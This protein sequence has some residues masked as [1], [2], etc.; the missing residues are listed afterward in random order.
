MSRWWVTWVTF[1]PLLGGDRVTHC[2]E[3]RVI[4]PPC[5]ILDAAFVASAILG[6]P[7][8]AATLLGKAS[9]V[10]PIARG[11]DELTLATEEACVQA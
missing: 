4:S 7:A 3:L 5:T 10:H 9:H 8:L 11:Q 1:C 2:F 6:N